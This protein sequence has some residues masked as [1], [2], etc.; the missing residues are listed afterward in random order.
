MEFRKKLLNR[1]SVEY[2]NGSLFTDIIDRIKRLK[3]KNVKLVIY[4][5]FE[6]LVIP[7]RLGVAPKH[8]PCIKRTE[9]FTSESL[10]KLAGQGFRKCIGFHDNIAWWRVPQY[11]KIIGG[12]VFDITQ[13]DKNGNPKYCQFNAIN[14]NDYMSSNATSDFIKGMFRSKKVQTMDI[15]KLAMI[16]IIAIGAIFGLFLLM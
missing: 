6:E 7:Q 3:F 14:L 9:F 15:Q 4:L 13:K 12:E 10:P 8:L 16:G 1:V 2:W 5:E 11:V